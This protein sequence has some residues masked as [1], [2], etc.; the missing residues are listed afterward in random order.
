MQALNALRF[1]CIDVQHLAVPYD[2]RQFIHYVVRE[3]AEVMSIRFLH[4]V[5]TFLALD[6]SRMT[7]EQT[8]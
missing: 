8:C 2:C 3:K 7:T 4:I 5:L 1:V 6:V